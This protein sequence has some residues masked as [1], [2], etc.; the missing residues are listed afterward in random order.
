[1]KPLFRN[2]Y[3]AT[4]QQD[5]SGDTDFWFEDQPDDQRDE[6]A[7]KL[8]PV[9]WKCFAPLNLCRCSGGPQ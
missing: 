4:V 5:G 7:R 3:G 1:M 9:C 6:P 2:P 8:Q